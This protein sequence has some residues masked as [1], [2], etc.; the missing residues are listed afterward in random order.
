MSTFVV[1]K[2]YPYAHGDGALRCVRRYFGGE[3]GCLELVDLAFVVAAPNE[4]EVF[5]RTARTASCFV[6]PPITDTLGGVLRSDVCD[7]RY[8]GRVWANAGPHAD[9]ECCTA[10]GVAVDKRMAREWAL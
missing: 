1:G 2:V 9:L 4:P 8:F 5:T 7:H 3:T 6:T 10:C